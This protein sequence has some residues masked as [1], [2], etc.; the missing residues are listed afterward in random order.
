MRSYWKSL[1]TK[2]LEQRLLYKE[3]VVRVLY[4]VKRRNAKPENWNDLIGKSLRP[5]TLHFK[6]N[7]IN[8]TCEVGKS[9]QK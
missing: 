7:S 4:S 6:K 5:L 1:R 3:F 8:E 2:G 9:D